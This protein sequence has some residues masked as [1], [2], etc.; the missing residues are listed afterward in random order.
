MNLVKSQAIVEEFKKQ[1]LEKSAKGG[2]YRLQAQPSSGSNGTEKQK[3]S[4]HGL[5]GQ[6]PSV[7]SE[8][9]K[10]GLYCVWLA[11]KIWRS[12]VSFGLL[13]KCGRCFQTKN[14]QI[15]S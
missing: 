3:E 2:T 14:E 11:V 4:F 5:G 9:R 7:D 12:R 6:V 8:A 15:F 1:L 13:E 10:K